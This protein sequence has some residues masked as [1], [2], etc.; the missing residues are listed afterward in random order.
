MQA[1]NATP[2][3]FGLQIRADAQNNGLSITAKNKMGAAQKTRSYSYSGR[4]VQN[5]CFE[6]S[7][8]SENL[9]SVD[10]F[11]SKLLEKYS[12]NK[13]V[14]TKYYGFRN[15]DGNLIYDLL[16]TYHISE[17]NDTIRKDTL[18]KY[19]KKRLRWELKK[20]HIIFDSNITSNSKKWILQISRS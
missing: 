10:S 9:K 18:L 11:H 2:M 15:V 20:W 5:Y 8:I 7:K 4:L 17:L 19:F 13:L 6:R 1:I 14:D 16:N 12:N 3:Q